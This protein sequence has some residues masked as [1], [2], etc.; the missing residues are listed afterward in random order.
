MNAADL[1]AYIGAAA[2]L[3]QIA[4]WIH[5]SFIKPLISIV[6]ANEAEL[7][8][9][10]YGPIF[11]VRI[12]FSADRKDAIID[13]FE[14]CLRHADGDARTF[15]WA[16]LSETFSEIRDDAGNRSVISR[17][18]EPVALKIG[19][20]SLVEKFVRF[21]E[22]RY[23]DAI[24]PLFVNL[25]THFNFLKQSG[26]PDYIAKVLAS[27]ELFDLLDARKKAF[28]W[29]PGQYQLTVK[30]SS[31]KKVAIAQDQFRF[32]LSSLD[33]DHLKQNLAN[34]DTE[35]QNVLKSNLP[36]FKLEPINWNWANVRLIKGAGQ[37]VLA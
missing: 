28:W 15:R 31:T 11:N 24:R 32:D 19:T 12:A 26:D 3:P 13:G 6:P 10:S 2:W 4:S 25:L 29:K 36:D 18:Q 34:L 9:S 23:H 5:G 7:G 1:A 33:V 21:Q 20:E 14:I 27:K 35:L 16:G 37:L 22:P 17:D 8:F 30:L